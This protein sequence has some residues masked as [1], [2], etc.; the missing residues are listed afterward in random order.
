[1]NIKTAL[2]FAFAGT[3]IL[4]ACK[5]NDATV[6]NPQDTQLKLNQIQVIGSHNSYHKRDTLPIFEWL[7]TIKSLLP[8]EDDPN[9]LDYT[10]LP[11]DQQFD[12]YP[13]RGIEIDIYND[14]QGGAFYYRHVNRYAGYDEASY[15]PELKQPGFKVLHIKD[16][17]YNSTYNTFVQALQAVKNWSDKHP[18]HLP[19]FIN[20]ESKQDG[21]ADNSQLSGFGFIP[22]PAW[23]DAAANALDEEIKS[24]FGP[25]L[26]KVLTPDRIRQQYSTL[27]DMVMNHAWPKLGDCRGKVVFAMEGNCVPFY[28]NG[29][30]SLKGRA[31]F[32][33]ADP[34]TDEGA[35][36][37]M[38][39][40][41]GQKDSI[42]ARVRDGY[43]V[44]TRSDAG[45]IEARTG[46]YSAMNAGFASGA[47]IISTDYYR[48]D[49]RGDSIGSGW[50][51][52]HVSFPN[53]ELARKNPVSADTVS[54]D[55]SLKE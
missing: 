42:T 8:P 31:C 17:D 52:F 4:A 2:C 14:P 10:H 40:A 7:L 30:P 28:K 34:G 50:T 37:L 53:G 51:N 23:D 19:I 12:H 6:A 9:E 25:N 39:D 29:H 27:H 38:N 21:P 22:A 11:F 20:I 3:I 26:D 13:V 36:L 33:Y 24:V 47:T 55:E 45:T 16:V 32:V 49:P 1:M 18:N 44:R 5:K 43:I 46:D 35:F 41:V 54:V 48:P 15:I